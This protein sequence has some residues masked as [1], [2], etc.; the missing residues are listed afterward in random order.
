MFCHEYDRVLLF[1]V[2]D[3]KN[4][5]PKEEID[6]ERHNEMAKE[7]PETSNANSDSK[8][9]QCCI[10]KVNKYCVLSLDR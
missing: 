1:F 5:K 6:E 7:N 4:L 3:F 2:G 9:G 8:D 10:D